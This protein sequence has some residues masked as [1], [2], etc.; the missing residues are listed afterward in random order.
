M[1]SAF[2]LCRPDALKPTA[3]SKS[4]PGGKERPP[5][6]GAGR[7]ARKGLPPS[8]QATATCST[9][10]VSCTGH[11]SPEAVPTRQPAGAAGNGNASP[12]TRPCQALLAVLAKTT[13]RPA[14]PSG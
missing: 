10:K 8:S 5:Q 7:E 2:A 9:F 11:S 4:P 6:A 14:R 13:W 3:V 1:A 12:Q